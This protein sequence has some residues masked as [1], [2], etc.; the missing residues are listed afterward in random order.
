MLTGAGSC[1][2]E[3]AHPKLDCVRW[4]PLPSRECCPPP[5]PPPLVRALPHSTRAAP[6]RKSFFILAAVVRAMVR[7]VTRSHSLLLLLML[8]GSAALLRV[9]DAQPTDAGGMRRE[10]VVQ[11]ASCNS[12]GAIETAVSWTIRNSST[13]LPSGRKY[14]QLVLRQAGERDLALSCPPQELGVCYVV[15][16]ASGRKEPQPTGGGPAQPRNGAF[17]LEE[18][19][20]PAAGGFRLRSWPNRRDL[21]TEWDLLEPGMCL[22]TADVVPFVCGDIGNDCCVGIGSPEQPECTDPSAAVVLGNQVNV[23]LFI[24][25][26]RFYHCLLIGVCAAHCR[27]LTHTTGALPNEASDA[28][29]ASESQQMPA[30]A[31]VRRFEWCPRPT[32]I[33][34]RWSWWQGQTAHNSCGSAQQPPRS[35]RAR[36]RCALWW[37]LS[38]RRLAPQPMALDGWSQQFARCFFCSPLLSSVFNQD[39]R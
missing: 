22:A 1:N 23:R 13:A 35:G 14:S 30:H 27:R 38:L 11:L 16:W 7:V 26:F 31:W 12:S 36:R 20:T 28:I 6:P 32:V 21:P 3:P 25:M 39:C 33:A 24:D 29:T 9:V 2:P 34:L 18:E 4:T 37:A 8:L 17:V 5:P 15:P 19:R 10:P